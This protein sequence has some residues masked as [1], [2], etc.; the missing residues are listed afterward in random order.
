MKSQILFESDNHKVVV[1]NDLVTG[2]GIQANQLV[3][4][5]DGHSAV[6]D[7]GGDLTYMPL[8]MAV[9]KYVRVKDIDFV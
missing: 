6:F 7:P 5:H 3:I 8:S 1:F 2:N 9:A 4:I